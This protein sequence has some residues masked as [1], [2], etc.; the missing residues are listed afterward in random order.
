[1]R[2]VHARSVVENRVKMR[3]AGQPRA[4]AKPRGRGG[5]RALVQGMARRE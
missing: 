5:G 2:R 3:A 1:M 4:A